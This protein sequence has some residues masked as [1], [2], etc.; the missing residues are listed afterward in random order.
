MK[1]VKKICRW[2]FDI[3]LFIILAIAL[4]MAYNH[5]QIN[6]K[7]PDFENSL[8]NTIKPPIT[9]T[10]PNTNKI[11]D[12]ISIL[13]VLLFIYFFYVYS[14]SVLSFSN[15][16]NTC[17][18]GVNQESVKIEP[19]DKQKN[20]CREPL[21]IPFPNVFYFTFIFL[22]KHQNPGHTDILHPVF[23]MV[24]NPNPKVFW[25]AP[26]PVPQ[27]LYRE[28]EELRFSLSNILVSLSADWIKE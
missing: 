2:I 25:E 9:S 28:N 4:I 17:D 5:I 26:A 1:V 15:I 6:I 16:I 20:I 18:N 22:D 14:L 13:F 27:F 8:H 19:R 10:A 21:L 11:I 12:N 23:E 7:V 24:I 3:I